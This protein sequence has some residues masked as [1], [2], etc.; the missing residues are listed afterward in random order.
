[1]NYGVFYIDNTMQNWIPFL[2]NLPNVIVN[3]LEINYAEN[4]IY[5]ATYGRGLW[6][7]PVYGSITDHTEDVADGVISVSPNP[8][9]QYVQIDG[10][11]VSL[12]PTD[13]AVFNVSGQQVIAE[14]DILV[15][16]Y[17]LNIQTL[18]AGQYFIRMSNA[19]GIFTKKLNVKR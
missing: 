3:E 2:N 1:M 19:K 18:P 12:M 4:R 17:T 15:D 10:P 11:T 6:S 14:K 16:H 13:I 8:A 5:A 9:S 7:S